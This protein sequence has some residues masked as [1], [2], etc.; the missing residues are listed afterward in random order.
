MSYTGRLIL[1]GVIAAL[2]ATVVTGIDWGLPSRRADRFL[3][4][5][6]SAWSGAE[7][8]SYDAERRND[9]LGADVDRDPLAPSATP[10]VVNP[11]D[12]QRA[13]IIRRYKLFSAQPDEMITFMALQQMRPEQRDFDPRLYQYGGLWI[14]PVGA[15]LKGAAMIGAV[16]LRNDKAF[17]YDRPQEFGRFYVVARVY[18]LAWYIVLLAL[19]AKLMHKLT[20]SD[21]ASIVAVLAVGA[22]P[23]VFAMAHEA[24]PHLPGAAMMLL[25]CLAVLRWVEKGRNR[26][27]ILAGVVCGLATGM[28]L[29]AAVIGIVLPVMIFL[30]KSTLIQRLGALGLSIAWMGFAYAI[31]NPYVP[32]NLLRG[33]LALKSNIENTRVMYGKGS[34]LQ[35]LTDG[36]S[37]LLEAGTPV[38]IGLGTLALFASVARRRRLS[39]MAWLIGAPSLVVLIQ[40]ALLAAGKPAE[41]GRFAIFPVIALTLGAVWVLGL[42]PWRWGRWTLQIATPLAVG[43][44]WTWA[45]VGAFLDDATSDGTRIRAAERLRTLQ[46]EDRVLQVFATPAPYTLPPLDV[47]RWEIT[48]TRPQHELVGDV[49]IRPIDDPTRLTLA[50]AGYTREVIGSQRRA[51]PITWADK[52]FEIL[53][54][55]P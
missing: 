44:I 51:A 53:I 40:F 26:D 35:G 41:Y 11:V 25:A 16:D 22:S 33:S 19:V 45:Y 12:A 27:A 2:A 43:A 50:P 3:F 4:A 21:V 42:I 46:R 36:T 38:L 48:L 29:S 10:V 17:Y 18:T 31:T 54:R 52:P 14:Y 1:W 7:L 47:W 37:R 13:Q 5:S 39:P 6:H 8:A 34:A 15:M 23:V 20:G 55:N 28:V 32:I 9:D 49:V 30:R 24:K